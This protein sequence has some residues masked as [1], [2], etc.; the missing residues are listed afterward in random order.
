MKRILGPSCPLGFALSM[1]KLS[2][3]SRHL[4]PF[5]NLSHGL[6]CS[7]DL[8]SRGLCWK[9]LIPSRKN[10]IVFNCFSQTISDDNCAI[11]SSRHVFL[12]DDT[13]KARAMFAPRSRAAKKPYGVSLNKDIQQIILGIKNKFHCMSAQSEPIRRLTKEYTHPPTPHSPCDRLGLKSRMFLHIFTKQ[14]VHNCC[15]HARIIS[16]GKQKKGMLRLNQQAFM[17][18]ERSA[19][20]IVA[21][22][23]LPKVII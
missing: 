9:P 2:T 6:F 23:W 8:F 12:H 13:F 17:A 16:N 20:K 11:V 7:V 15:L 4:A 14:F 3:M 22:R 10:C 18:S 1:R 5:D 19:L 21:Q